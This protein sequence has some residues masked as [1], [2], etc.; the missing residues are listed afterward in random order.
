MKSVIG[1]FIIFIGLYIVVV[2]DMLS[3]FA[4]KSFFIF[5]VS[6]IV[7]MMIVAVFVLGLPKIQLKGGRQDD[8]N[9]PQN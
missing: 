7:V 1:M 8:E 6:A 3:F 4:Q 9:N 2:N 5:A